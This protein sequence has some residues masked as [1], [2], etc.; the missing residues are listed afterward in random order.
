MNQSRRHLKE[1]SLLVLIFTALTLLRLL[2]QC[3]T[4]G[5]EGD[6]EQAGVSQ[7]LMVAAVVVAFVINLIALL[8]QLYIGVKGMKIAKE[9]AS[10]K[11]HIVWAVILLVFAVFS[12]ISTASSIVSQTN[13]LD[14]VIVIVDHALHV[15]V[16]CAY[17]KYANQ[18]LKGA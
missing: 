4:V 18:V 17:I 6:P 5:F 16:Y 15:L 3:F 2:I 1:A 13:I 14:N 11:G 10:T 12:I 8:P 7:E 9:P